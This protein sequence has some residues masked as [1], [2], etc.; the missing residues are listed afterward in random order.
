MEPEKLPQM[1]RAEIIPSDNALGFAVK[2]ENTIVDDDIE[3]MSQFYDLYLY[4]KKIYEHTDPNAKLSVLAW[5]TTPW[6]LP[7]NM[8]LAVGNHIRYSVVY[9]AGAKEYFVIAE[10]LL[11]SYYRNPE[12]YTLI[13]TIQGEGL[14]GLQYEPLFPHI[15]NSK[16]DKKYKEQF[17]KIIP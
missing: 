4:E 12:E 1:V 11:K 14:V 8:F 6:T 10:N 5:T 2:I 3:I 9:D 13:K 16:I 17:F 15:N 7:S